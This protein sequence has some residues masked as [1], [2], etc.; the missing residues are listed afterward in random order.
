MSLQTKEMLEKLS[1]IQPLIGNTP[2]IKLAVPHMN[3]NIFAK[4]EYVNFAGSIKSRPAFNILYKAIGDGQIDENSI[5]VE[6]S[7]GNFAIALAMLCKLIGI[8]FIPVIDPNINPGYEKLLRYLCAEVIKVTEIDETG[9][10]LLT[11]LARVSAIRQS[12][13][14]TFWP[15]QYGNPVNAETYYHYM[16]KEIADSFVKLDYVF[17]GVSS[18]GTIAGLSKKLKI[19]FPDIKI[20]AIDVEGSVIFSHPPQ[21]RFI[22]GIGSSIVPPL[23]NEAI[24]DEIIHISQVDII[25]GC[26]NLVDQHMLF[27]GASSGASYSCIKRYFQNHPAFDTKPQVLFI[28]PDSGDAYLDTIYDQQWGAKVAAA[29]YQDFTINN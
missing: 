19:E 17:I 23:I 3:A 8:R 15:N 12:N 22:S 2:V 13:E 20:I 27:C 11:R 21:K 28:C 24:I 29:Q 14:H 6:S 9:G 16:A 1:L 25:E 10:Y 26:H 5:V 4:L 7:S 18:C